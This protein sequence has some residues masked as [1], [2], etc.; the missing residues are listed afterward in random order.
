VRKTVVFVT[1]D[2]DEAVRLGDRIAVMRE[3]GYLEQYAAPAELLTSPTTDFVASFVGSDRTIKRL[4]VTAIPVGALVAAT[5]ADEDAPEIGATET[6]RDALAAVLD[7]RAGRV[8]V[9]D[10]DN[11]A[12]RCLGVLT[13]D[14]VHMA[15][16][17]VSLQ[18]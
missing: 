18:D 6:M 13:L 14:A 10:A 7:S 9:V 15:M 17:E 16:R 5:G 12:R 8:R 11:G 2:I 3:G 4:A 1:H